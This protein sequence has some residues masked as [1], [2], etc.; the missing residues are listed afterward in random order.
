[1]MMNWKHF[2]GSGHGLIL[3]Y[4][5]GIRLAGLRKITK[6]LNYD[7]LYP[8]PRIEPGISRIRSMSVNHS[9]TTFGWDE[10]MNERKKDRKN[11]AKKETLVNSN[12]ATSVC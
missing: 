9:I 10:R 12:N 11:T 8:E 5:P 4:Y 6:T 1:M 2:V 7:S 3:R